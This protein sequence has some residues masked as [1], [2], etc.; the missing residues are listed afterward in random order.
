[1]AVSMD[2]FD[3]NQVE[4][5]DSLRKPPEEALRSGASAYVA[6]AEA[7]TDFVALG[8]LSRQLAQLTGTRANNIL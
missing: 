5:A 6:Y 2:Q 1:M 3:M 7:R 4:K 8:S